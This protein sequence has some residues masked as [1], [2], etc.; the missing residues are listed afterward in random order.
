MGGDGSF[1]A[2]TYNSLY[3]SAQEG[4]MRRFEINKATNT[5]DFKGNITPT[6]DDADFLFI[7]PFIYDPVYQDR[8]Y[9]AAKGTRVLYQ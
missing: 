7:N 4:Q 5:F 1:N 6:S 3:V 9:V 2:L 8:L